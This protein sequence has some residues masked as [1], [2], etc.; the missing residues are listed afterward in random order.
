MVLDKL[1]AITGDLVRNDS[2]WEKW[3]FVKFTEALQLWTRRNPLNEEVKSEL[4]TV[5]SDRV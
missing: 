5:T 2:A 4:I 3:N 1:P